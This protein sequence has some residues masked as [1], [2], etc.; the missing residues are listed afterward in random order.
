MGEDGLDGYPDTPLKLAMLQRGLS[1]RD[2]QKNPRGGDQG[3]D[4]LQRT[5][6]PCGR[7]GPR[8]HLRSLSLCRR[9]GLS[10]IACRLPDATLVPT[11]SRLPVSSLLRTSAT[12]SP[13]PQ[14]SH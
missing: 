5:T 12:G 14:R 11:T 4:L 2:L 1:I 3:D 9:V 7:P 6:A 13:R 8:A 10:G